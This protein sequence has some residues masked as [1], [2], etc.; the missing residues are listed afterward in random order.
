MPPLGR[1]FLH[2]AKI[3]FSHPRTGERME[4]RAPLPVELREFLYAL[5]KASGHRAGKN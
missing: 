3:I 2:A 5:A 4:L 1:N